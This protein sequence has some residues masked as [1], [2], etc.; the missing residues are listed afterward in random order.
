MP[1][2]HIQRFN[3]QGKA[4]GSEYQVN[5]YSTYENQVSPA[6]AMN[7]K[8]NF[9]LT[10]TSGDQD[11]SFDGIFAQRFNKQGKALGPVFQVNSY[12]L[13]RQSF[14]SVAINKK[15][16]FVITWKSEAQDGSD[17][18]IFAQMFNSKGIP[19][20]PEFQVNTTTIG[21]QHFPA[22]AMDKNGNFVIAWVCWKQSGQGKNGIFAQRFNS[23]GEALGSEFQVNTSN[24]N[25]L[26]YCAIAM[27]KKG[28][29]VIAWAIYNLD[30]SAMGIFAQR[31]NPQGNTVGS[32]F[33]VNTYTD[34][35][36][37]DPAAAMDK[38]GNFVITWDS[39][40][41][42]GS[43]LGVFAKVFKK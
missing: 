8:G 11:G 25:Y 12:T 5:T 38:R 40:G 2:V 31:F 29:F 34:R 14:P 42:D 17:Y 9:V 35:D 21:G 27:D 33:Q 13:Y 41:Q 1:K 24:D 6:I 3:K 37:S 18:G 23:Q 28:N 7:E 22:V 20:G 32:E 16:N 4:L 10:W 15:G 43:E 36:Q 19:S 26:D 39:N 30:G